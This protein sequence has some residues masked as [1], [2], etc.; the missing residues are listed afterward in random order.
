MDNRIYEAINDTVIDSFKG[1]IEEVNKLLTE[2]VDN[3]KLNKN[4]L[5]LYRASEAARILKISLPNIYKLIDKGEIK[6]L[7]ICGIKIPHHELERFIKSK[8]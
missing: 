8:Y 7:D 4:N 6:A 5:E 2:T 3:L 1:S